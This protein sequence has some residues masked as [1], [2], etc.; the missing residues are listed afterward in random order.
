MLQTKRISEA[1]F[2]AEHPVLLES[3][4]QMQLALKEWKSSSVLGI[5]TEFVRERTYRA[6][7]GLVQVS[8]GRTAWLVDPVCLDPLDSLSELMNQLETTKIL[9]SSSEDLEVLLHTLGALPEPMVDTQI[10]CAMLGQPLQMAYRHAVK[11]LFDVEIDKDQTRSNWCRRPLNSNQL[12]YAAMDVVLL[13]MML[14]E[15]QP[16]LEDAGRWEWLQEDVARLQQNSRTTVQPE[17]AYLRFPGIGRLDESSLSVLQALAAWREKT[18]R[19]R[20]RARGFVISDAG[21]MQLTRLKPSSTKE[22]RDVDEIHPG[23]L[24][25]YQ[26]QLLQLIGEAQLQKF[27]LAMVEQLGNAQK[28]QVNSMRKLVRARAEE[29]GVDPA[30]LASKRELEKLIRAVTSNRAVPERFLGWRKQVITE[31]LLEQVA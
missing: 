4:A 10:A 3:T 6:D 13:P 20:N 18:A 8:D 11:W 7:L 22:I 30:L 21:L 27:D 31:E 9:H 25:R 15:L 14:R 2:A 12:R 1:L 26:D 28:R 19:S 5:D 16:R 29:L 17:N 23:A 24:N